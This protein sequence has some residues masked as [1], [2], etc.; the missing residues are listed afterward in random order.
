L[1][2]LLGEFRARAL[3]ILDE[4][5]HA[6]PASGARYA[7]DS[8]FTKA[9]REIARRFEHRLFLAATPHNGHSNSFSALLEILDPQRFTRGVPVRPAELEPVIVRR[10][11]ADLRRLDEESFPERVVEPIV[12]DGLPADAPELRL[13]EHLS[14]YEDL[15]ERRI[16]RLP[17]RQRAQAR[18]VFSG[19]QQRLLSSVAAFARTLTVHRRTLERLITGAEQAEHAAVEAAQAFVRMDEDQAEGELPLEEADAE[20]QEEADE[21][22]AAEQASLLGSRGGEAADLRAELAAVD[23][24]L[25]I[26]ENAKIRQD[27]RA[28]WL[29]SWIFDDLL[30]RDIHCNDRRLIVFTEYEDTRRWLERRL[31]EAIA[32]TD[33]ADERIAVFSGIT[34]VDRREAIKQA[35][36]A[37]PAHEPLRILICTDAAREGINLQTRCFDL[38]HFDLPWN[39]SRLEQRNG[40]IDRKFQPAPQVFCRYFKYVQREEDIVLEALVRKTEVIQ[41]QLGSAGRVIAERITDRLSAG[42]I[43]KGEARALAAAIEHEADDPRVQRARAEMDEN[44]ARRLSKVEAEIDSLRR[45]LE[46]ARNRVG[47]EPGELQQ[48][49]GIALR[50]AGFPLDEA[51]REQVGRVDAFAIDPQH[52]AFARDPAWQDA[53]DDLRARRRGRRERP[54]E[55]RRRVPPRAIAFEPPVEPDGRDADHVVQVHLEHRLVRRLLGRFLSQG[56]QSGLNRACVILG[57]G[58]QPRV[59]LLGRVALYGPAAARLHEEIIEVTAIWTE[60]GRGTK[61]LRPLGE[62]GQETTLDQLEDAL[63]R[64]RRPSDAVV[65]RALS[66]AQQ[67]VIDLLPTLQQRSREA[68]EKAERQLAER[69][70]QEA[71]SLQELLERQRRRI[72]QAEANFDDRQRELFEAEEAERRQL[73][74]DRSLAEAPGTDRS[75]ARDG[76]PRVRDGYRVRA[77]RLEPVGLVYL[78]PVTG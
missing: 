29:K 1:R 70:Q 53:F 56:F 2:D 38:V 11:K 42:G 41:R 74:A 49:V 52:P 64:S 21:E 66:F 16:A 59:V 48:V 67:D 75:R 65:A 37:D 68:I 39:P 72:E 7:I 27:A 34:G 47:V 5:H 44:E 43:R 26:A 15:R 57:P 24:M 54:N 51:E 63:A 61:P 46:R 28:R 3:L 69:G 22:A 33:R 62:R 58:A 13:A 31:K 8:Q 35:F 14:A 10:L 76:P 78:W 12:I 9:V 60:A 23:E 77:T 4:A 45:S 6:A 71:S 30:D 55:W 19:L 36:N 25:A 17:N 73:R 18:L 50:R 20:A 40:R 32:D